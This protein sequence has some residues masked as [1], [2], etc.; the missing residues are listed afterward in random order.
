MRTKDFN[1]V[2]D[3]VWLSAARVEGTNF[4]EEL[5]GDDWMNALSRWV[6]VLIN[7]RFRDLHK[8]NQAGVDK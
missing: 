4:G 8:E 2:D 5:S 1:I 3:L 6:T 7:E